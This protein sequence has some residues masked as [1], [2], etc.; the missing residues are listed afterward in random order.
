MAA[1]TSAI[2][3]TWT[4]AAAAIL[5]GAIIYVWRWIQGNRS[6]EP[7]RELVLDRADPVDY[8]T[9]KDLTA[10]LKAMLARMDD[11]NDFRD[12][13]E[14][15]KQATLRIAQLLERLEQRFDAM[16]RKAIA[17]EAFRR[18]QEDQRRKEGH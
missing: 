9:V 5:G 18:G 7:T 11:V 12:D 2:D 14:A 17:D 1:E 16:E 6:H 4:T 10:Q 3:Q 15:T 13:I 8:E